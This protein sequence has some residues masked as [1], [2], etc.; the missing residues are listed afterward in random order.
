MRLHPDT[1]GKLGVNGLAEIKLDGAVVKLKVVLD[2]T[3]PVSVAL[4]PRSMGFPIQEPAVI[5]VNSAKQKG[6]Q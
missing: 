6:H 2:E 4:L 5:S 3:V 1:A